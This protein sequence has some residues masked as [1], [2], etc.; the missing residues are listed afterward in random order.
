MVNSKYVNKRILIPVAI[1]A[2]AVGLTI[3][4]LPAIAVV[5]QTI[6]NGA[7]SYTQLPT[8]AGSVNVGQ[9]A[10][11]FLKDNLKVSFLQA[12]E[13]AGKQV[14]NGTIVA[15]HLGVVRGYLV[16][17]FFVVNTQDQTRH[18]IMVDAGNAKVL[19]ASQEHFLFD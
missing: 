1:I 4:G 15:G 2:V 16:Y 5:N 12:S 9:T 11:N 3:W 19:Y 8:I 10:I 7:P 17:I 13:I 14:A 18:L 6:N